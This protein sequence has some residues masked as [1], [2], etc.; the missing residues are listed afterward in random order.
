MKKHELVMLGNKE[1][2]AQFSCNKK[3]NYS[4]LMLSFFYLLLLLLLLL[5]YS[6]KSSIQY[7]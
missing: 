4:A 5:A 7:N 3:N 6:N 1:K 2:N